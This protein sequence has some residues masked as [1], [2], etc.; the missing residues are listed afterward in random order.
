[1]CVKRVFPSILRRCVF[2]CVTTAPGPLG[3]DHQ[4]GCFANT[5]GSCKNVI[6]TYNAARHKFPPLVDAARYT[7][8]LRPNLTEETDVVEVIPAERRVRPCTAEYGGR[9]HER[10]VVGTSLPGLP[11]CHAARTG[12]A[13][14]LTMNG[15]ICRSRRHKRQSMRPGRETF[16]GAWSPLRR[17]LRSKWALLQ[18]GAGR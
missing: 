4:E 9:Y 2:L 7:D 15:A 12:T 17:G 3:Q 10:S 18:M 14:A 6:V 1:M 5:T 13:F 16:S 11:D 8:P